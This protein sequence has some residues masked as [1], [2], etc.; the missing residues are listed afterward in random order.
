M[1]N[2]ENRKKGNYY[3]KKS[4]DLLKEQG[5]QV[6][7]METN[8]V[9]F[10]KGRALLFHYDNFASDILAMSDKEIIFI[11]VKFQTEGKFTNINQ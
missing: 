2:K 9:T 6:M 5:Y 8:K 1:P 11:Q 3:L 7:R 4:L 10:I